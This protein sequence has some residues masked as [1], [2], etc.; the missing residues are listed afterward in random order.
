MP[1]YQREYDRK[2]RLGIVGVGSHSY[3]NIFP[4]LHYLPVELVALCDLDESL[5]NATAEEFVVGQV[6]GDTAR[7]YA[8]ANLDA[9]LII[10]SPAMHPRLAIEAMIAGVHVW[11]EKP[12]AMRASEVEEMIRVRDEHNLVAAVGYKKANMPAT[13]K[14]RELLQLPEFGR[15]RSVYGIYPMSIPRDGQTA[16]DSRQASKWLQDGCHPLSCMVALGG[17]VREVT[18]LLGDGDDP[19]G[20]LFL[21]YDNGATGTFH[22]TGKAPA[23]HSIE[24]Y[25]LFGDGGQ[26]VSIENVTRVAYHRGMPFSYTGQTDFTGPGTD[27]GSVVWEA[28]NMLGTPENKSDFIQGMFN[29]LS[30]FCEAILDDR[31]IRVTN[32]EFALNIMNIYEAALQSNGQPVA[33]PTKG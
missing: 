13:Y 17:F 31:P 6:Y 18:V 22:I 26:V 1:I 19:D 30:D 29:E 21:K 27:T 4:A 5:A 11:T 2:L 12:A 33:L 14:A 3:R 28:S 24:R 9:V 10:V 20:V 25:D 7:M 15:L 32:L 23:G 8:E 16:L